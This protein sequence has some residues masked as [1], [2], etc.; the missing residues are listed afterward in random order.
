[1]TRNRR[2]LSPRFASL[3]AALL[4]LLGGAVA[5]G[6]A[7]RFDSGAFS[8]YQDFQGRT[9][10]ADTP[11]TAQNGAGYAGGFDLVTWMPIGGTLDPTLY[12]NTRNWGA[13]NSGEYKFD[14]PAPGT[15]IVRLRFA[16]ILSHGPGLRKFDVSIEGQLVP[17]F[18]DFDIYAHASGHY[19]IDYRIPAVVTDGQLNITTA[20]VLRIVQINAIEVYDAIVDTIPPPAPSGF[21]VW[22]S[23]GR[24]MFDWADIVEDDLAGYYLERATSPVGPYQRLS[25]QLIR[26][27]RAE[28]ATADPATTY[29]YRVVAAD[30]WGNESLPTAPLSGQVR[31]DATTVLPIYGI[32]ISQA[33]WDIIN[34][35]PTNDTYVSGS[36][37]YNGT[38]WTNVGIRYRGRT[39]RSVAKKSW[40]IKFNEFVPGQRFLDDQEE[41]NLDSEYGERTMIREKLAWDL[42]EMVGVPSA[43]RR[44]VQ[45]R[46]NGEYYG[47]YTELE[48]IDERWL[49]N[50]GFNPAGNLYKADGNSACL[51]VLA[52]TTQYPVNYQKV[53]NRTEGHTDLIQFIQLINSTPTAQFYHTLAPIFDIESF[54]NYY[55]DMIALSDDSFFCHNYYLYHDLATNKW[56]WIPYDLDSTFGHWNIFDLQTMAT[57]P[58]NKGIQNTLISKLY[59]IPNFKRRY[60]E[61]T[62][63]ILTEELSP[64]S[65]NPVIDATHALIQDDARIDWRK[66]GWEDPTWTDGGANEVKGYIPARQNYAIPTAQGLLP[67]QSL[68]INEILADNDGVLQDEMGDFDDLIEI[69]NAGSGTVSLN[70]HFL[71]DDILAPMKWA[72]PDTTIPAGSFIIFWADNEPLEGP[73][74]TNFALERNGEWVGIFGPVATGNQ[75]IDNKGFANQ[76]KD[77]SFG[78]LPDGGYNWSLMGTPTPGSTNQGP[79]NL[80]PDIDDAAHSPASAGI[81][82]PVQITARITDD[83]AVASAAVFYDAGAPFVSVPMTD[84]GSDGDEIAG[85]GI[86][87]GMI[88]GQPN[89]GTVLYYVSAQ[90]SQGRTMTSPVDAPVETFVYLIGF[91][92]PSL[93]VNEFMAQNVTTITD[94]LGQFDD[95]VELYNGGETPVSLGGLRLTD[96]ADLPDKF[97]FP[98][99]TLAAGG[100]MLI[101]CDNDPEQGPLH[102]DFRLATQGE[103]IHLL[104][105]PAFGY[106]VIDSVTFTAQHADTSFGR[107]P[108]GGSSWRFYRPATPGESNGA[109]TAVGESGPAAPL[110]LVLGP[111]RPNPASGRVRLSFGLPARGRASLVIYDVTGRAVAR[112]FDHVLDR[113]FHETEWDGRTANGQAPAG[114]YFYRLRHNGDLREGKLTLLR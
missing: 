89:T 84:D 8:A 88:P 21:T 83:T 105:G 75:P 66:W 55:A 77:V 34:T 60:L 62:M 98:D 104:A 95:W 78:R 82:E 106:A 79:G 102:A 52:D 37:T 65:F 80:P 40:K 94:E 10:L 48:Q 107:Q 70:G 99:T 13:G 103:E 23:Y 2:Q 31:P 12:I 30:V 85:D 29:Y 53:T 17:E 114:I 68:R 72:I 49:A 112:L 58:L 32:T 113:G 42:T 19:A 67:V 86:F 81:N 46:V 14:V 11:Y 57:N 59:A 26:R 54:I 36:F 39:S 96:N 56:T 97:I 64:S 28:D 1:M 90:D 22:P 7:V 91:D 74:H 44:H 20:L 5:H 109:P 41:V 16:D 87:T 92:P 25:T 63:E 3:L 50:H 45:F 18:N 108:D 111:G 15:Y 4:P 69:Y 100:F 27:S 9:F 33:N 6:Y 71:T 73:T 38:T 35:T 51:T 101:W 76:I 93:Y 110:R 24:I 61:R 47:V 43:E